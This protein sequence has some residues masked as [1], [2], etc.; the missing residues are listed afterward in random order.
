MT[1]ATSAVAREKQPT[2]DRKA[3]AGVTPAFDLEAAAQAAADE[4]QA[5]PVPFILRGEHFTLP[6]AQD[7]PIEAQIA[8]SQENLG[9][10]LRLMIGDDEWD[11]FLSV[12]PTMAEVQALFQHVAKVSGVGDL[13]N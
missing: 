13:G 10:G 11:R 4:A 7:W 2:Q 5:K 3:P 12:R 8:L 9:D 1:A 6:P